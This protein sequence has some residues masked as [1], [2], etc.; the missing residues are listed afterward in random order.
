MRTEWIRPTVSNVQVTN[1]SRTPLRGSTTLWRPRLGHAGPAYGRGRRS[2]DVGDVEG[3]RGQQHEEE[4]AEIQAHSPDGR[5]GNHLAQRTQWWVGDRVDRLGE[6]E[7]QSG[8]TPRARQNL[9]PV[10]D[11][12]ADEGDEEGED[13]HTVDRPERIHA[14]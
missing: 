2:E 14:R 10:D 1:Q 4:K 13:D 12:A 8:R 5:R 7:D 11:E 6:H 9:H 3:E